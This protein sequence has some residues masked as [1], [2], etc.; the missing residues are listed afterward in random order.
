MNDDDAV[1]ALKEH[2]AGEVR[3]GLFP[4]TGFV[5]N[6]EATRWKIK[7]A[8]LKAL[9]GLPLASEPTIKIESGILTVDLPLC[10]DHFLRSYGVRHHYGSRTFLAKIQSSTR[11]SKHTQPTQS[12][13]Q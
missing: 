5:K 2:I 13:L 3:S 1:L 12:R 10:Y 6:D 8:V 11:Q 7:A 9:D 4:L